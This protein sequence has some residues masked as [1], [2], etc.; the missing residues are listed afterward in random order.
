MHQLPHKLSSIIVIDHINKLNAILSV[1]K[2]L[3]L[4]TDVMYYTGYFTTSEK[5]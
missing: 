5:F 2:F 4:V 3:C 1:I